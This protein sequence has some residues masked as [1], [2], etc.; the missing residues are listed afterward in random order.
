MLPPLYIADRGSPA[1]NFVKVDRAACHHVALLTP[2]TL[3]RAGLSPAAKVLDLKGR[4]RCRGCGRKGR[5]V[6]SV[7]WRGQGARGS[8]G[9][10]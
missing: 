1:I 7:K 3:L 6:V 4:L 5:A 10:R 2:E 8:L 9:G